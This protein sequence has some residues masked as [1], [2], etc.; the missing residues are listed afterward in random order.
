MA[1]TDFKIPVESGAWVGDVVKIREAGGVTRMPSVRT[2]VVT[3][4]G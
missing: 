1:A 2:F 4:A 3:P